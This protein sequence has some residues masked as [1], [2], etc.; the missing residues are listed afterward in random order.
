MIVS[1]L[2]MAAGQWI[3]FSKTGAFFYNMPNNDLPHLLFNLFE[4]KRGF[5]AVYR[6]P[7][8]LVYQRFARLLPYLFG[9]SSLC[10]KRDCRPLFIAPIL[11]GLV[12]LSTGLN[13]AGLNSYMARGLSPFFLA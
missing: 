11:L 8:D 10:K 9:I 2:V 13:F 1:T 5:P 12:I 7:A 4:C 3:F 6:Q